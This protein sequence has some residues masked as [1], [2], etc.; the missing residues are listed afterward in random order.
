MS[1]MLCGIY[2]FSGGINAQ[3]NPKKSKDTGWWVVTIKDPCSS[4]PSRFVVFM[5]AI[6]NFSSPKLVQWLHIRANT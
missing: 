6:N 2:Q 5:S 4:C 1:R 3:A